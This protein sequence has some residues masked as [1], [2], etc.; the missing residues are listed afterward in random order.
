MIYPF[1]KQHQIKL[2]NQIGEG[3]ALS[4][5]LTDAGYRI[6]VQSPEGIKAAQ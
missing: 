6:A 3:E 5:A 4:T 2:W 1:I